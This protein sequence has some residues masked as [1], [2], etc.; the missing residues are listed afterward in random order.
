MAPIAKLSIHITPRKGGFQV[1][2]TS[3]HTVQN[4]FQISITDK[5]IVLYTADNGPHYN[6]WPDGGLSPF[7]GE[8]NTNW[9]GGYRVPMFASWPGK[10]PAGTVI[11]DTTS[12]LD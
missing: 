11:N 5:T 8:K 7:R 1:R 4:I 6:E 9:E 2:L 3:L 10:I 12:A